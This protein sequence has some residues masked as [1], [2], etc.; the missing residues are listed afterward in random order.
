MIKKLHVGIV[1]LIC[2]VPV[3]LL[4]LL[5][6]TGKVVST[7]DPDINRTLSIW[8]EDDLTFIY[9]RNQTIDFFANYTDMS[10]NSTVNSSNCSIYINGTRIPMNESGINRSDFVYSTNFSVI[11]NYSYEIKCQIDIEIL[12]TSAIDSVNIVEPCDNDLNLNTVFIE[13]KIFCDKL[14]QFK[15]NDTLVSGFP[16]YPWNNYDNVTLLLPNNLTTTSN[17][18]KVFVQPEGNPLIWY[19]ARCHKTQNYNVYTIFKNSS[20][21]CYINNVLDLSSTFTEPDLNLTY[22]NVPVL[23]IGENGPFNISIENVGDDNASRIEM[24]ITSSDNDIANVTSI[25]YP[26]LIKPNITNSSLINITAYKGGDVNLTHDQLLYY[27]DYDNQFPE[28]PNVLLAQVHVNYDPVFT[29]RINAI[30][31]TSNYSVSFGA[32]SATVDL[33]NNVNDRDD[34]DNCSTFDWFLGGITS[35]NEALGASYIYTTFTECS[36]TVELLSNWTGMANVTLTV[37]DTYN[38]TANTNFSI[39]VDNG[40]GE[41]CD[42]KDNDGDTLVDEGDI[43]RSCC[44]FSSCRARGTQYCQGDGT[45]G[46]C[47]G[48]VRASSGGGGGG[49][50]P[51]VVKEEVKETDTGGD[52]REE[53]REEPKEEEIVEAAAVETPSG[54][55]NPEEEIREVAID[56]ILSR[57]F[58]L[59]KRQIL[60]HGGKTRVTETVRNLDMLLDRQLDM[61][62]TIPK[63]IVETTDEIDE[64][65]PFEVIDYDPI[66]GFSIKIPGNKE[67]NIQYMVDRELT[68][69]ELLEIVSEV[70]EDLNESEKLKDEILKKIKETE[71]VVNL[72]QSFKIDIENNKTTLTID[73]DIDKTKGLTN[74]SIFQ[75]IPKC[76][77]EIINEQMIES[78]NKDYEI[79]NADPVIVWHFDNILD[80]E[81]IQYTIDAISD[82]NCTNQIKALAVAK[83]IRQ[84]MHGENIDYS[85]LWIAVSIIPIIGLIMIIFGFITSKIEHEDEEVNKLTEYI[86]THYRNGFKKYEVREKLVKEGHPVAAVEQCLHLHTMSKFH[87]WIHRLEIGFDELILAVLIILNILDF[88]E[89]LPGDIDY[90]KKIISWVLLAYLLYKSSITN[91][92]FGERKKFI[93]ISLLLIFFSMTFKNIIGYAKV[94]SDE[95]DFVLHLYAYLV[96]NNVI[97]ERYVFIAAI[98]A[99]LLLSLYIALRIPIKEPSLMSTLHVKGKLPE[100]PIKIIKRFLAVHGALL[101]FFVVI[102]NLMMEWLAIA[103]DALIIV[104]T[105]I[106]ML[107][108]IIKHHKKLT[109]AK[110]MEQTSSMSEKFYGKFIELF[111]YKKTIYLGVSGMLILHALTEVGNF[112]I[113]YF[114]GVHDAI[115]FGNFNIGHMPLFSWMQESLFA[116]Q[117]AGFGIGLKFSVGYAYVMNIIALVLLFLLPAFVWFNYFKHRVLPI[118]DV[119][120]FRITRNHVFNSI[121]FGLFGSSVFMFIVKPVFHLRSLLG[122]GNLAGVD[123]LTQEISFTYLN[124]F[125]FISI[126]IGI[127]FFMIAL[128][129]E[130]VMNYVLLPIS[131]CFFGYYIFL[132]AQS[133]TGYHINEFLIKINVTPL[134]ALYTI[135][136]GIIAVVVLYACGFAINSYLYAPHWLKEIIRKIPLVNKIFQKHEYHHIHFHDTH[137]N[138]KHDTKEETLKRYILKSLDSGHELFYIV[139][140][141][142]DHKWPIEDIE[143]A[144]DATKHD[145]LYKTEVKHVLHYHHNKDGIKQ[146]AG[147]IRTM[148]KEHT[149][150]DIIESALKYKWTE[151]DI[152]L[153]FRSIQNKIRIKPEDKEIMKYMYVVS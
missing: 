108:L 150:K 89:R 51:P 49:S 59:V 64:I 62:T 82:E 10:T 43:N 53:G 131:Y 61:K 36:M 46:Q 47:I 40:S 124:E 81:R 5:S 26:D 29:S 94:A 71:E 135:A 113:P 130:K 143:R 31:M 106:I 105:L 136:F 23:V 77:V 109:P 96:N 48:D 8:V 128:F 42:N 41:I 6:I 103:V 123:I 104:L 145:N 67:K 138:M 144:I 22:P 72:T 116:L 146:L 75:E 84:Y 18:T 58:K 57:S 95:V 119:G 85:K 79:I 125:I 86:R 45:W 21:S 134:I 4:P 127:L 14:S 50:R 69:E 65:T 107:F 56:N 55:S 117:T 102:F 92:L 78:E 24:S 39:Y 33:S 129:Y 90:L 118:N 140:H 153:A 34:Y 15:I 137:N 115:Y 7:Y 120:N 76:L 122:G 66:I 100:G 88:T 63:E 11:G 91:V 112:I 73:I 83:E 19:V 54:G 17:L 142:V 35:D 3:L 68:E 133:I 74:V 152:I 101:L 87:Y 20:D 1:M 111:H 27:G 30:N 149:A 38:R 16:P 44:G 126:A 97:F 139:E 121:L 99:L 70:I 141:L 148:Y 2:L 12:Y 93:D 114:I 37:N 60:V 13:D 9:Y 151:D 25:S 28:S 110:F 98:F 32:A 80:A 147:W 132:F 52:G